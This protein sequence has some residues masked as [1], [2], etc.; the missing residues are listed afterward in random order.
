MHTHRRGDEEGRRGGTTAVT[1]TGEE[2]GSRKYGAGRWLYSSENRG[3]RSLR[4]HSAR[5]APSL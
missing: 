5:A 2:R 3:L 1:T 4:G